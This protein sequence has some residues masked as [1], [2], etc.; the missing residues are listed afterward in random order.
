MDTQNDEK[1][2]KREVAMLNPVH[3]VYPVPCSSS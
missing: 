1:V 3:V 2:A